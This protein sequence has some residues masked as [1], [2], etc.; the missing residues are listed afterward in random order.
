MVATAMK[1]HYKLAVIQSLLS[2]RGLKR[3]LLLLLPLRMLHDDT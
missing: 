1:L 2:F 3:K